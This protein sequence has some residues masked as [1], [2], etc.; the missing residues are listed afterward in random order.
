MET[1]LDPSL[2]RK[3]ELKRRGKKSR[4]FMAKNAREA[5]VSPEPEE[6][7]VSPTA[8]YGMLDSQRPIA[9]K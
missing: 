4:N 9:K 1:L 6:S 7:E 3:L 5:V 8:K 2:A